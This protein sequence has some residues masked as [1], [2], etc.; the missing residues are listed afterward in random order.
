[1]NIFLS[2]LS[3]FICHFQRYSN[4]HKYSMYNQTQARKCSLKN[5]K[6]VLISSIDQGRFPQSVIRGRFKVREQTQVDANN[7]F[8]CLSIANPFFDYI[9]FS[10]C[11]SFAAVIFLKTHFSLRVLL[12]APSP[13]HEGIVDTDAHQ[14]LHSLGLEGRELIH[15]ARQ[16]RLK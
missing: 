10:Q 9:Y 1:M 14:L 2:I 11:S 8:E 4:P 6:I 15:I 7:S 3:I 16:V 5:I 12:L 13:H